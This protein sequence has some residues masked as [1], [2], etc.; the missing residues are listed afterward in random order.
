MRGG[1][2]THL[3]RQGEHSRTGEPHQ[4]QREPRRIAPVTEQQ[5]AHRLAGDPNRPVGAQ[6]ERD[7]RTG[8]P[9]SDDEG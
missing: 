8:V 7:L 9:D 1:L 3:R 6:L 5:L 2:A 4:W